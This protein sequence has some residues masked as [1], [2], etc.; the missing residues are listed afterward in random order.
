VTLD[1]TGPCRD[2]AETSALCVNDEDDLQ[3]PTDVVV[4]CSINSLRAERMRSI[5]GLDSVGPKPSAYEN[6][7]ERR[8]LWHYEIG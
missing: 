8:T 2:A 7:W 5:G 6:Q 1:F 3:S 4:D